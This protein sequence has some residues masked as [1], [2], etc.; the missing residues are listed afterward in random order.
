MNLAIST[1]LN[2]IILEDISERD[3]KYTR[4]AIKVWDNYG[5][6]NFATF[7]SRYVGCKW[8]EMVIKN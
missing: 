8:L 2:K 7:I 1:E 3:S 6:G 5:E 4:E